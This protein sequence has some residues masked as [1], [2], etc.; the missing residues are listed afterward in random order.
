MSEHEVKVKTNLIP[1]ADCAD[2][3]RFGDL[4]SDDTGT[5]NLDVI[6]DKSLFGEE[7][8]RDADI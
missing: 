1:S 5:V 3:I 2:G 7:V 6:V 8:K 4:Y